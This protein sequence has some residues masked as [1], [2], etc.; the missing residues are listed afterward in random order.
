MAQTTPAGEY[1]A[2][3]ECELP[4]PRHGKLRVRPIRPDD[5]ERLKDLFSRHSAETVYQRY[6][7]PLKS[8]PPALVKRFVS[9]DYVNDMALVACREAGGREQFVAVGRYFKNPA[10][11]FAEVA[12]TVDDPWQKKGIGS[13]LLERLAQIARDN[14]IRGFTASML[15][16]NLGMMRLFTHVLGK[17][18]SHYADGLQHVR[19]AFAKCRH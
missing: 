7:T 9:V 13:F 10:D 5:E 19:K 2:R 4:L 6:F 1:P 3:Y 12:I 8:L 11:G 18:D 14:G 15:A 16:T 17:H